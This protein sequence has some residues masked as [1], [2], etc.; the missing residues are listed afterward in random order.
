M[1]AYVTLAYHSWRQWEQLLLL[2]KEIWIATKSATIAI[3]MLAHVEIDYKIQQKLQYWA[4][5]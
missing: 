4:E 2:L 5:K 1:S 3:T